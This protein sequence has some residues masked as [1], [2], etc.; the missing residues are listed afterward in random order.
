MPKFVK[1][2]GDP[3]GTDGARHVRIRLAPRPPKKMLRLV[4][5]SKPGELPKLKVSLLRRAATPVRKTEPPRIGVASH[6]PA[7]KGKGTKSASMRAGMVRFLTPRY[8]LLAKIGDGGS[9][10]VYKARD[11][12]LSALVAIKVLNRS[13]T[14]DKESVDALKKEA[15][16]SMYLSHPH[17]VRLHTLDKAG[18]RYFLVMEHIAGGT[19][20]GLLDEHGALGLELVAQVLSISEDA[21]SYAHRKGVLHNDLKP[22]NILVTRDGVLKLIDFGI[23]CLV[24][25]RQ[26]GYIM[27]TP[28]YMSPEQIRGEALDER[29]DVYS[30]G[31]IACEMLTGATPFPEDV[32]L[33]DI[34]N[35]LPVSLSAI[36]GAALRQT[37]EKAVAPMRADRYDSV[38]SFV[39][40]FL[41]AARVGAGRGRGGA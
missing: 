14:F 22:E 12:F 16:T 40:A 19:L 27:G 35:L 18:M 11:T 21:L 33:Q 3:G 7:A 17:I 29:N 34:P 23:A 25:T 5:A 2:S 36:P 1:Q 10:T 15:L 26:R 37:V 31:M 41:H 4:G 39:E 28:S 8:R 38:A 13:L 20:R 9:G 24:N 6:K 32:S 30:L